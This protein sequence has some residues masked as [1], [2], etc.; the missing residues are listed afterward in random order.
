MAYLINLTIILSYTSNDV[1]KDSVSNDLLN[2]PQFLTD[3][4]SVDFSL[5][6]TKDI[7]LAEGIIIFLLTL[8]LWFITIIH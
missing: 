8:L 1:N 6:A 5:K 3:F 2:E 7:I 4:S